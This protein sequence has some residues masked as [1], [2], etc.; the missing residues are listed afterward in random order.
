LTFATVAGRLCQT[1]IDGSLLISEYGHH[2]IAGADET[3]V[4][5]LELEFRSALAANWFDELSGFFQTGRRLEP[6]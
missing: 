4:A 2:F 6:G 5:F 1:L 3:P